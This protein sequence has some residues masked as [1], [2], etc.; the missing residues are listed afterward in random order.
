MSYTL[1]NSERLD[2]IT[3][4]SARHIEESL[5]KPLALPDWLDAELSEHDSDNIPANLFERLCQFCSLQT[6]LEY[7][8]AYEYSSDR[9]ETDLS[10]SLY[11]TII[12]PITAGDCFWSRDTFVYCNG[13]LYSCDGDPVADTDFLEWRIGYWIR[14]LNPDRFI[15]WE[16][17]TNAISDANNYCS[18][19]YSSSPL[20]ELEKRLQTEPVYCAKRGGWLARLVDWRSVVL[21][22]PIGPCYG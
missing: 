7:K 17:E 5:G 8:Y 18:P 19:G 10:G 21:I 12:A 15:G 4:D 20:Y 14:P 1:N 9:E 13:K 2:Q 16:S 3:I 11:F 6:G 22:E